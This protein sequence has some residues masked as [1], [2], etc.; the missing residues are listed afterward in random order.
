MT[1]ASYL[2][3]GSALALAL[4]LAAPAMAQT[5]NAGDVESVVVSGSRL[6]QT[7]LSSPVPVSSVSSADIAASG[8]QNIADVLNGLPSVGV[9]LNGSNS[10]RNASSV[11]LNEISLRRLGTN[12]T[13]TLVDGHRQVAATPGSSAVDLNTIPAALVDHVEVVTGGTS[14]V[15]GA[16]A[17]SGVVNVILKKDF[18]GF[19]TRLHSGITA[20]GDGASYGAE[21]TYGTNV[22]D[23]RGNMVI[24]FMWDRVNGVQATNR[25]W[26]VSGVNTIL[27]PANTGPNTGVPMFI[28]R[29]NIRFPEATANGN[30][31]IP[32]CFTAASTAP[33]YF[34]STGTG[35][36]PFNNGSIGNQNGRTVGGDGGFYEQ[37]DNLSL[38]LER[39]AL[40]TRFNYRLAD[41]VN[42]FFNGR[43]VNSKARSSWQPPEDDFGG[44]APPTISINNPYLPAQVVGLLQAAGKTSFAYYDN[45]D[46]FGR[47]T[48]IADRFMQQYT[49]GIEGQV[50]GDW[51]YQL[52]G[53]Y[54]SNGQSTRLLNGRDYQRFTQSLNAV[55]MNGQIVCADAA[56]RAA[57]CQPLNEFGI[58]NASQAAINYS[59]VN[60]TYYSSTRQID[61]GGS[62]TGSLFTL[63]AGTVDTAVGFELRSDS[64]QTDP[65]W[66]LQ[67]GDIYYPN[68]KPVS[69]HV[70]A[71]EGFA[72]VRVPLLKGLP[73]VESLTVQAAARVSDYNNNGT[74]TSWNAGGTYSPFDWLTFRGMKSVSVRAPNITELYSPVNQSFTFAQDPCDTSVISTT[75]NRAANCAAL[76]IPA[77]YVSSQNGHTLAGTVGGNPN[78]QPETANTL[79]LGATFAPDFVPGLTATVDYF[80]IKITNA[81]GTIPVQS[82][83]NN[84]VDLP[85]SVTG[86]IYCSFVTRDANH[87]ITNVAATQQNVGQLKTSGIDVNLNYR[88]DV[89][90][91]IPDVPG[92][93]TLGL[94]GTF[95]DKLRQLTD[96]SNPKTQLQLEGT[97]GNPKFDALGTATYGIGKFAFT[98]RAHYISSQYVDTSITVAA[99]PP[100]NQYDLPYTGEKVFNDLSIDYI[101]SDDM[102][103]RFNVNNLFNTTPPNRGANIHQGIYNASI[104]PNLGTEFGV[105]LINQW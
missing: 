15:Y 97:L 13:L 58:G 74:Q 7:Y 49:L 1:Y 6:S 35:V 54:G 86:N 23:N 65:S 37:Y 64:G 84:C 24:D 50:F 57:G 41:N 30:F 4:F 12:R 80:N 36:T 98:W 28:T 63:P 16:D 56:A 2:K 77:G 14:A 60:D 11:G 73:L 47:R 69:G 92:S 18:Q 3:G 99:R 31:C 38:P 79:T 94:T 76:G 25:S 83:L 62:L 68:E 43:F 27:N 33:Y 22:A 85:G 70:A 78:L 89:A 82:I 81:I 8:A 52:Y 42:L 48:S 55:T 40:T 103:I 26:G 93:L 91:V 100:A 44:D 20:Y 105:T 88:F 66:A 9:G 46:N 45:N 104:Y 101:Y 29:P 87:L 19:Q 67:T 32:N 34:N 72:E 21:A 53:S 51:N 96:A 59:R 71:S 5:A 102:D 95:L 10:Q 17:V 39:F 75:A 61:G 90:D